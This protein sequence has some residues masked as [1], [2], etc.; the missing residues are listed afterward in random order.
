[1]IERNERRRHKSEPTERKVPHLFAHNL[2]II[3]FLSSGTKLP[4]KN[5][6]TAEEIC[7]ASPCSV[8]MCDQLVVE[9]VQCDSCSKWFHLFCINID[10]VHDDWVCQCCV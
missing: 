3:P 2:D 6:D 10:R 1:M 9:W 4:R 8:S 5:I 7:E